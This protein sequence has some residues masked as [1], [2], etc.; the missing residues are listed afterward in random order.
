MYAQDSFFDLSVWERAVVLCISATLFLLALFAA[1]G[2]RRGQ[3]VWIRV[4]GALSIFWVF[5]WVSPQVYY[6][7]YWLIVP[8][9]PVQWV[10]WPPPDPQKALSLLFFQGPHNLSAHGKGLLGWALIAAPFLK[11]FSFRRDGAK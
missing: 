9:L 5:V 1:R 10:I 6:Q 2:L 7:Y 11:S 3:S 4:L 8:D